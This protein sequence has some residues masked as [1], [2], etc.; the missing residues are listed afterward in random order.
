MRAGGKA[1]NELTEERE[2]GGGDVDIL[3]LVPDNESVV[4]LLC[5]SEGGQV[6]G[7]Y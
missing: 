6:P 7:L 5:N 4:E 2:G 3:L 1:R